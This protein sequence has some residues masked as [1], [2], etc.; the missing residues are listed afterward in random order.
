MRTCSLYLYPP[1]KSLNPRSSYDGVLTF[2]GQLS[3]SE[4]DRN[5]SMVRCPVLAT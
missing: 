5:S 3:K 1:R 4:T 2:Y